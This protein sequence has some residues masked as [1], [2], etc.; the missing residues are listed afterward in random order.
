MAS[1][2]EPPAGVKIMV[3][4]DD[5]NVR[6]ATVEYLRARGYD[7]TAC[8]SGK[9]LLAQ[10]RWYPPPTV[11][12]L[13]LVLQDMNAGQCLTALHESPWADVPVIIYSGWGNPERLGLNSR[14]IV[15]KATDPARLV[16]SIN[17]LLSTDAFPAI[18]RR[19]HAM[20]AAALGDE[21]R[22]IVSHEC[23]ALPWKRVRQG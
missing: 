13:D 2:G 12:V 10:A 6:K 22:E 7:V 21:V 8:G 23:H 18:P 19:A 15:R 1:S 14:S 17:R 4:D 20:K 16:R 11:I 5:V 9:A 3:V